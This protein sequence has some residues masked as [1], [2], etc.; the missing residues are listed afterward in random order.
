MPLEGH[1]LRKNN[2]KV[3]MQYIYKQIAIDVY[4]KRG[5]CGAHMS[6][7][8]QTKVLAKQ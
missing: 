7:N 1:Q 6:K 4:G 5:D 3:V 2:K 8:M